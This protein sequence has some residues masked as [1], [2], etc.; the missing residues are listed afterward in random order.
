MSEERSLLHKYWDE[1]KY[2]FEIL[3]FIFAVGALFLAI[4]LS[5]D[6]AGNIYLNYVKLSWLILILI[7]LLVLLALVVFFIFQLEQRAAKNIL[8][9]EGIFVIPILLVGIF[10]LYSTA[11][12]T[13]ANYNQEILHLLSKDVV[14]GF[15]FGLLLLVR[16]VI[17]TNIRAGNSKHKDKLVDLITFALSI[18]QSAVFLYGKVSGGWLVYVLVLFT[19]ST[20]LFVAYT[21]TDLPCRIFKINKWGSLV[22]MSLILPLIF[23]IISPLVVN[24][25]KFVA[26]LLGAA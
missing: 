23:I 26:W 15:L 19:L 12:Y 22:L 17:V 8:D 10:F 5:S 6:T 16:F 14:K 7:A 4:P 1:K 11:K 24:A 18:F 21:I 13:W 9:V 25:L 20:S 2:L 3:G